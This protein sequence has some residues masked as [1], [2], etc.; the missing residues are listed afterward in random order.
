SPL[1]AAT[2]DETS[3]RV[4]LAGMDDTVGGITHAWHD[5]SDQN[6]RTRGAGDW[7]AGRSDAIDESRLVQENFLGRVVGS[8]IEVREQVALLIDRRHEVAAKPEVH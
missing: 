3:G 7:V 8:R 1:D 2:V 4:A 6:R 5:R